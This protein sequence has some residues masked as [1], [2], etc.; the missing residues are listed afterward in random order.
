MLWDPLLCFVLDDLLGCLLGCMATE[1]PE[2]EVKFVLFD[3]WRYLQ[4]ALAR[5]IAA[6]RD[7]FLVSLSSSKL[8]SPLAVSSVVLQAVDISDAITDGYWFLHSLS[9]AFHIEL[10]S[11]RLGPWEQPPSTSSASGRYHHLDAM[12]T[13]PPGY[14]ASCETGTAGWPQEIHGPI[15]CRY[16]SPV[17]S[18]TCIVVISAYYAIDCSLC[19]LVSLCRNDAGPA[20]D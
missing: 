18:C 12:Q 5:G 1:T 16:V 20:C 9:S 17:A 10:H 13:P 2:K 6:T 15:C 4:P 11:I 7:N 14:R 19:L 8:A 3:V